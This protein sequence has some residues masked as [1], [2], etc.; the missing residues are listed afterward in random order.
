MFLCFREDVNKMYQELD[1]DFDGKLS[2]KEFI[3]LIKGVYKEMS[4]LTDLQ[5]ADSLHS[6]R[7]IS[8]GRKKIRNKV[9][10]LV[11]TLGFD[12]VDFSNETWWWLLKS[13]KR[14]LVLVNFSKMFHFDFIFR[15]D[16]VFVIFIQK[17]FHFLQ[18]SLTVFY[19]IKNF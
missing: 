7:P 9:F 15:P 11:H 14:I 19:C 1:K 12:L 17:I 13:L 8:I 16:N 10:L 3:G 6:C 18:A 2:W 4:F 5:Q